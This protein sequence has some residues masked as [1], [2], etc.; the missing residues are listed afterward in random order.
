MKKLFAFL[1]FLS[2]AAAVHAAEPADFRDG[3]AQYEAGRYRDAAAVFEKLSQSGRR[4]AAVY[5]N[6]GNAYFRAGER[7]KALVAYER[8]LKIEPRDAD[9]RWNIETLKT[10]LTDRIESESDSVLR[11]WLQRLL[12]R[13]TEDEAA[14]LFSAMMA[15]LFVTSLLPLLF[16]KARGFIDSLRGLLAVLFVMVAALFILKWNDVKNPRVV[17]LEKEIFARFG[18]NLKETKAFLLHEGAE[19]SMIDETNGWVYIV[20]PNKNSGWIPKESCEKI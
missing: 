12:D 10:A 14:K 19:A 11:M 1:V 5:Y 20:L 9:T 8:A 18:P 4:T 17:V 13:F 2:A 3:V 6:L 7:A 16:P 15:A